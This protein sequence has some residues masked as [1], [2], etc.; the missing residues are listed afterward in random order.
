MN[1]D[2]SVQLRL[3]DLQALDTSLNQLATRRRQLPEHAEIARLETLRQALTDDVVRVEAELFDVSSTQSRIEADVDVVRA[4]EE[5]DR[6]RLASGSGSPKDLENLQHELA[7]LERRQAALEDDVLEVMEKREEIETR[8]QGYQAQ[9]AE[10]VEEI[11]DLVVR[12]DRTI[13]EIDV[14]TLRV[15]AQ[16]DGVAGELPA[17]LVAVYTRL[18]G[19]LGSGAARLHRG[20]CEGCRL[21]LPGSDIIALRAA[22]ADLVVRCEECSRILVRTAESGL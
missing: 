1:A 21:E 3:L 4:R 12:R 11:D 8:L 7:S 14:D 19:Q 15:Q 10:C 9:R 13:A 22:P 20:R 2:P 6:A 16:R 18:L 17:D 5:R